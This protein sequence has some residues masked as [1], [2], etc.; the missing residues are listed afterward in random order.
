LSDG[1]LEVV[2]VDA[3]S[4]TPKWRRQTTT[5]SEQWK[6]IVALPGAVAVFADAIGSDTPRDLVVL[7]G[8]NGEQ[9]WTR[10]LRGE[11]DVIFGE[12]VAVLV[13]RAGKR[14]VGLRLSDGDEKWSQPSPRDEYD[15]A[16]TSVHPVL[17][18]EALGGPAYLDGS[19]RDPWRG[20]V[21]R[22]VQVGADRSVRL[23]EM[24]SGRI[25]RSR[26][27]VADHDDL[28][29][30]HGDRLYVARDEPRYQL[31]A[32][33]LTKDAQPTVLHTGADD[34][35]RPKALVPCGER[36]ACLL[37]VTGGDDETAEVVAATEKGWKRWP[38]PKATRLVPLGEH[39]LAR[40][41]SP[42]SAGTLF[43]P[44]GRAVLRDRGGVAVRLD[45]GNLLLFADPPSSVEDDRSVA[46]MAVGSPAVAEMGQL[47]GVR[48]ETCSW[49]TNVIACGSAKDFVLYRFADD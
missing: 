29:V 49:N 12:D 27:G 13:D 48:S 26:V 4:G 37:E 25:V 17:T 14:L 15:G 40:R 21:R 22:I 39:V 18:D 23:V 20:E 47:E 28:V 43:D 31:L 8:G 30:A 45:A 33:D 35:K 6:G 42:E 46:G 3:D 44:D 41:T 19:P 1:R 5:T 10:S 9:R 38:A 36:R 24:D 11:D 32:Y 7:D 2:A 16:R 34:R